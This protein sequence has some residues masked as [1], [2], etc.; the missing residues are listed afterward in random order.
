MD[1]LE[2][3]P[4]TAAPSKFAWEL[5][6]DQRCRTLALQIAIDKKLLR[7]ALARPNCTFI[8]VVMAQE[9]SRRAGRTGKLKVRN[10]GES[11]HRAT[12]SDA[13]AICRSEL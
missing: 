2:N 5:C 12:R 6:N 4:F 8:R 11:C 13:D 1:G 9:A 10:G 7:L 3:T